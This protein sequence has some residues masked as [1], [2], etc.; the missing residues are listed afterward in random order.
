MLLLCV[1]YDSCVRNRNYL[2]VMFIT[3]NT[4]QLW[5]LSYYCRHLASNACWEQSFLTLS[6]PINPFSTPWKHQKTL[7]I[8][9]EWVNLICF[10]TRQ[11]LKCEFR[12]YFVILV[13]C[14]TFIRH[15]RF[16]TYVLFMMQ[17]RGLVTNFYMYHAAI[18]FNRI[19]NN[20]ELL[21]PSYFCWSTAVLL[22]F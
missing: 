1:L 17:S 15:V 19:E 5:I 18:I 6:F 22:I 2:L 13:L 9:I 16:V 11:L 21:R 14:G 8:G 20:Y 10:V 7:G 12:D 4:V 3:L